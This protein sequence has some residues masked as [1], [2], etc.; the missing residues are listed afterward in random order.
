MKVSV[1]CANQS[2]IG[3]RPYNKNNVPIITSLLDGSHGST[4]TGNIGF[5]KETALA[6]T[7]TAGQRTLDFE[8]VSIR[9]E[10]FDIHFKGMNGIAAHAAK[11]VRIFQTVS[12]L[13]VANEISV[14]RNLCNIIVSVC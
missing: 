10:L 6:G 2:H 14:S 7:G 8:H 1:R 13:L 11:A 12:N 4:I 3:K 9:V 5:L